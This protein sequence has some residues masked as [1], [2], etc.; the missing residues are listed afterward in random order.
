MSVEDLLFSWLPDS[1]RKKEVKK[2]LPVGRQPRIAHYG[3]R[4]F[5]L[6]N[7][8]S[9]SKGLVPRGKSEYFKV[10]CI[11]AIQKI[12]NGGGKP[13][14]VMAQLLDSPDRMFI[15]MPDDPHHNEFAPGNHVEGDGHIIRWSPEMLDSGPDATGATQRPA[16]IG[17]V[18]EALHLAIAERLRRIRKELDST[19]PNSMVKRKHQEMFKIAGGEQ[20]NIG[21][22]PNDEESFAVYLEN[23]F[24]KTLHIPERVRY[25]DESSLAN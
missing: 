1:F 9:N 12:L 4:T 17:L 8:D 16:I 14:E 21:W 6:T 2:N 10:S 24:R 23:Q 5:D 3:G 25:L 22:T 13:A 18:H 7:I 11:D 15:E 20:R 19:D